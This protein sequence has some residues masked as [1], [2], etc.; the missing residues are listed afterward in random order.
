MKFAP[1]KPSIFLHYSVCVITGDD[2]AHISRRS[3]LTEEISDWQAL[4]LAAVASRS[5][6]DM[7]RM[8]MSSRSNAMECATISCAISDVVDVVCSM[9]VNCA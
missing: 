3:E 2:F 6:G 7:R 9:W 5:V 8:M 4:M 1:K